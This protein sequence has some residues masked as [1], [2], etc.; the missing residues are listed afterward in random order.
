[1]KRGSNFL[2]GR[3]PYY[4][5]YATRDRRHVAVAVIEPRFY[6]TLI[7]KL[8][9]DVSVLNNSAPARISLYLLELTRKYTSFALNLRIPVKAD[10]VYGRMADTITV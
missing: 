9:R 4:T 10:T 8:G 2:D 7:E 5:T 1:M 6:A 3:A